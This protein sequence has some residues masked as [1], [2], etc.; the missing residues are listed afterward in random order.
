[1]PRDSLSF[2]DDTPRRI[3]RTAEC[4]VCLEE[5]SIR[6]LSCCSST[7]CSTCIYSHLSS[8]INEAQIRISCPSCPHILTR[9]EILL[10]LV[11][12]DTNME[13]AERYKRFYADINREG[14]IKTCPQCCA[15]KEIDKNLV[16]GIRWRKTIPRHVIC[17]Y[18]QFNWCFYCHAPWHEKMTCKEYRE[19]EKMLR[20]WASETNNNQ[21][22]AQQCPRCKVRKNFRRK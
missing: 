15:I 12:K 1:V 19:G 13:V 4:Q 2:N 5:L 20:L 3:F 9:E 7:V 10:L 17:D 21:Q 6:P 8:H 11:E 14:H 18:C 16:E 22:N